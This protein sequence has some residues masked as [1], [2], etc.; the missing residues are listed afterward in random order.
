MQENILSFR[1][2]YKD[3]TDLGLKCDVIKMKIRS[4][5]LQYSNKTARIER[6]KEKELQI[7]MNNLRG[8]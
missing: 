6:D 7:K 3:V 8:K 5:T 1:E 2:K 4:F